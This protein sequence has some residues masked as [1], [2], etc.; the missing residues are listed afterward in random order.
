MTRV[1]D[2]L[3]HAQEHLETRRFQPTYADHGLDFR[4]A[5]QK[6]TPSQGAHKNKAV[7]TTPGVSVMEPKQ[8]ALTVAYQPMK[9]PI[10]W[11]QAALPPES[12]RP[13][14]E[15]L[16][17]YYPRNTTTIAGKEMLRADSLPLLNGR[18]EHDNPFLGTG[19]AYRRAPGGGFVCDV[20]VAE[21]P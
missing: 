17:S 18:Y 19:S 15:D 6:V 12:D 8:A 1:S 9:Q 14:Y 13:T 10:W 3:V 5:K 4:L 21:K 7:P 16:G 2:G 20:S 11:G